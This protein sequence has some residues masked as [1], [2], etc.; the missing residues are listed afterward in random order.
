[1]DFVGKCFLKPGPSA[2]RPITFLVRGPKNED[3]EHASIEMDLTLVEADELSRD[4]RHASK[5]VS[6]G[7][8][9]PKARP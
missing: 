3:G 9:Q 2:E 7:L 6:D 1:M 5:W 4:L 8:W